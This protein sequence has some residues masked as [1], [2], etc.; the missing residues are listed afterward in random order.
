MDSTRAAGRRLLGRRRASLPQ[1]LA[2]RG[3]Q[4]RR[5][6]LV[7]QSCSEHPTQ[8]T[9]TGLA[10][11][12]SLKDYLDSEWALRP[13]DL[14]R[15]RGQTMLVFEPTTSRPLDEMI[16]QGLPI[17]TFLRLAI[18]VSNTIA[19]LHRRGLV[20]KDIKA[21]NIL[22]DPDKGDARLTGFGIASRLPRERQTVEPPELIAGTLSHM[23]PEQTGR[24]NRSIDS[25]SDLYSLGI[26]LYQALSGSLPFT[27]NEPMEWVHCHIARKPAPPR[28]GHTEIPAAARRHH[29][30]AARED[31]RGTLSDSDGGRA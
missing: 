30:E 14:V 19:R 27:A 16:G 11:E 10:H 23:A 31:A 28:G 1:N 6:F 4:G 20:H 8:A 25:R 21:S 17:G 22:I 26:T 5:E 3:R 12:H 2:R 9:V 7:A 18:A 29:H 13:L 24:M 15:E